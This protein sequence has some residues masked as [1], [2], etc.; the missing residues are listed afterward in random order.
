MARKTAKLEGIHI[1]R[2][3]RQH[4]SVVVVIPKLVRTAL[5]LKAGDYVV[6]SSHPNTGVAELSKFI[7]GDKNHGRDT[8]RSNRKDK[9]R[10]L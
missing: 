10:R 6:F 1:Q 5:D 3:Q 7:P 2:A 9:G 4:S 8:G